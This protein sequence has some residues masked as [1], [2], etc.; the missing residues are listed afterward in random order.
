[1]KKII[2]Y[3]VFIIFFVFSQANAQ[4]ATNSTCKLISNSFG[5]GTKDSNTNGEVTILQD[6]L[7][8]NNYLT[9][10]STGFYGFLTQNAVKKI[11]QSNNIKSTGYVGTLT[12]NLINKSFCSSLE[13]NNNSSS[14]TISIIS[15]S[16]NKELIIGNSE[17][18]SWTGPIGYYYIELV[19]EKDISIGLIKGAFNSFGNKYSYDWKVG[20]ISVIDNYKNITQTI[21]KPGKYKIN[22][23][24]I[25][26]TQIDGEYSTFNT[27]SNIF[28]VINSSEKTN[29]SVYTTNNSSN[30]NY[31]NNIQQS[32]TNYSGQT[33]NLNIQ[34]PP[35]PSTFS[36]S[37]IS[38][39][40]KE[41]EQEIARICG[42]EV[43]PTSYT[44]FCAAR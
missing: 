21:L 20:N 1:M 12:K 25:S 40:E 19:N 15:P 4:S 18:I 3:L 44:V 33:L 27:K 43:I 6:Y 16:S 30:I 14:T 24:Y 22:I 11:Q 41:A 10:K 29:S 17:N 35:T 42:M 37:S 36:S 7:F 31:Q 5:Y 2:F 34:N 28:S 23:F 39:Q 8:K 32:N 38:Q 9:I 26:K 13:I